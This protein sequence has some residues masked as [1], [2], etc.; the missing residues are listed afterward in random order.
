MSKYGP[1]ES[2]MKASIIILKEELKKLCEKRESTKSLLER[3]VIS[4]EIDS[5]K[6]TLNVL[7]YILSDCRLDTSDE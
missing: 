4:T 3:V 6:R 1:L 5:K 7:E 2:K